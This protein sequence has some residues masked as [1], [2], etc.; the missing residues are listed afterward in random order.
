MRGK[1]ITGKK[2][3]DIPLAD[4]LCQCLICTGVYDCR[5]AY[6][7]N[8]TS[9][10]AHFEDLA[11]NL[12]DQCFTW[13]LWRDRAVHEL[14]RTALPGAFGITDIYSLLAD[15]YKISFFD[16]SK[17]STPCGFMFLINND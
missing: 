17:G 3:I 11:G 9:F 6:N 4:H 14:K 13:P 1:G 15:N 12:C 5:A 7:G 16:P 10:F 2:D 8:L